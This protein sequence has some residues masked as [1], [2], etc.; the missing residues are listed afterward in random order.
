MMDN[1]D[2]RKEEKHIWLTFGG[3]VAFSLMLAFII[4]L[5]DTR[6][7]PILDYIPAWLMTNVEMAKEVLSTFAGTLFSVTTFTFMAMLTIVSIYTSNFSGRVVENFFLNKVAIRTLGIF[8]GGFIY[9]ISSLVFMRD[10][11]EDTMVISAIIAWIYAV[12]A[13]VYFVKFIYQ[14]SNYMQLE[15]V[16]SKLYR[17]AERVYDNHIDY[18]KDALKLNNLPDFTKLYSYTIKADRNAYIDYIRFKELETCC[19]ERK[20]ICLIR[21]QVGAFVNKGRPIA[22]FYADKKVDDEKSLSEDI[23]QFMSYNNERSTVLDP[24]YAGYKLTDIALRAISPALNDP[25]TAIHV[26]HYKSLLETK[27][28]ELPG[29]YAVLGKGGQ[30]N[31]EDR[32]GADYIGC[33]VYDYN[34]FSTNLNKCYRQL[35]F[36]MQEDISCVEAIFSALEVMAFSAHEDK[37]GMVKDYSQYVYDLTRENFSAR[38]DWT[39]IEDKH[40]TIMSTETTNGE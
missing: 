1:W 24:Y 33:I 3:L 2:L 16:V 35:V 10:L 12:L 31:E 7:I 26:L 11:P 4:I 13:V 8:L 18:F 30:E 14:T 27:F 32:T 23:N 37:L 40:Q 20:G 25:N 6:V 5:L 36:Y 17:E 9:S 38:T 34:D 15:K 22:V 28:A 39:V 21:I 19:E 29:R